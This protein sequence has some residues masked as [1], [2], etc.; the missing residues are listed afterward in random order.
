[1]NNKFNESSKGRE[2]VFKRFSMFDNAGLDI[3][4]C[5]SLDEALS[6]SGL[7][8]RVKK[9]PIYLGSGAEIPN[10]Y[11]T[12][13]ED[14]ENVALGIVG[15][16]YVPVNNADAF[17]VAAELVDEGLAT[18]EV[19]G[20]SLGSRNTVDYGRSFMVL[21]G[22]DFE[23]G[24]DTFN[25]FIVFNN[26]FDGTTGVQYKVICQRLVCLNGMV[27]YLG[28]K[29]SQLF[30]NIQHSKTAPNRIQRAR[31]IIMT[32]NT[33]LQLMKEEAKA[34]A[35][36]HFSQ[37][38]FEKEIIPLILKKKGMVE[39]TK[40]RERGADRVERVVSELLEAYNA[41]D[42]QNYNNSAYKVVLA[43]SDYE[44]HSEPLRNVG[45]NQ[46]Y[47]NRILKGMVLTTTVAQYIANTAPGFKM[48]Y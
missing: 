19:G 15:S 5:T 13:R 6:A 12:V 34:F 48:P 46:V 37:A 41:D 47:M 1:M 26:S 17:D 22:E 7:D 8:Y 18:Y 24:D 10:S 21:R 28:G 44:S 11:A 45:N 33:E 27:R 16:Q 31:E 40:E 42:T 23:I 25:S 38:Q 3:S 35:N 20:P 9:V 30:I 36:T 39:N 29:K 32:H 43:L 14:N 4:S 2:V